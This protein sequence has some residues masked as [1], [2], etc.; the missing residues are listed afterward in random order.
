MRTINNMKKVS[1]N[2]RKPDG[3]ICRNSKVVN[4]GAK[5]MTEYVLKY[6]KRYCQ[7]EAIDY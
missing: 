5:N 3:S 2:I 4:P 6:C 7:I 1:L